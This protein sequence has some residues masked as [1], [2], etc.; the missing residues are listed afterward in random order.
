MGVCFELRKEIQGVASRDFGH[1]F[2]GTRLIFCLR[3][4]ELRE[5]GKVE[6]EGEEKKRET[7]L[8]ERKNNKIRKRGI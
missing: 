1:M 5:E 4:R 3:E 7:Y 8:E 2:L 6:G